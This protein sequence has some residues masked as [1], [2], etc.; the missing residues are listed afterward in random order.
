M[1]KSSK[2]NTKSS[3]SFTSSLPIQSCTMGNISMY[4]AT[5]IMIIIAMVII[6]S[7]NNLEHSNCKCANL[8]ERRFIK[9]WFIFLILF[10]II[11]LLS[12][13][14]SNEDCWSSFYNYPFIYGIML[15]VGLVNLVM[16]IR[17]FL[18]VRLLRN[19]CSCGYGNKERFIYWYLLILFC[20]WGFIFVSS[21]YLLFMSL[22]K[23]NGN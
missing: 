12:F 5:I 17:L 22:L 4:S 8:P 14:L 19:N 13:G 2:S 7:L 11:L 1:V 21:L 23:L 3:S 16:F 20:I 18:Y 10:Y 6:T 15:I 9:E